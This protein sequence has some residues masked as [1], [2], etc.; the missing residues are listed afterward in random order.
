MTKADQQSSGSDDKEHSSKMITID[1]LPPK[2][3]SPR[4]CVQFGKVPINVSKYTYV[5]WEGP[6]KRIKV[7]VCWE[8]FP[9]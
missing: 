7:Y 8:G 5:I 4:T 3:D 1:T 6:C 9:Y 2:Q